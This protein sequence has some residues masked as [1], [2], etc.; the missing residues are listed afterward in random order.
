MVFR[1][2]AWR[3]YTPQEPI[4]SFEWARLSFREDNGGGFPKSWLVGGSK[5]SEKQQQIPKAF[6]SYESKETA[7]LAQSM[8]ETLLPY[9]IPGLFG[10]SHTIG[11]VEGRI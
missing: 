7:C 8:D 6:E 4:E 9:R 11:V 3:S 10:E 1:W 5:P 2:E